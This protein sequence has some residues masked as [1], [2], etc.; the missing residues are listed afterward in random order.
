MLNNRKEKGIG[1]VG[2][3]YR[4]GFHSDFFSAQKP[5][6]SWI[7]VITENYLPRRGEITRPIQNLRLLRKDYPVALH[8][9]SLSLGSPEPISRDYLERVKWLEQ[10]ID[11]WLVSDHLCWTGTA[12]ENLHDLLPLPFTEEALRL[13]AGK[14]HLVQ[15]FLQRPIAIEN[16]SY[17][18]KPSQSEMGEAEFMNQLHR[19]T[20]CRFLLDLNNIYVNAYNLGLGPRDFL[21]RLNL[22]QVAE[23]HLAGHS[24]DAN[25]VKVDTHGAPVHE[26][27]WALYEWVQ[28][29]IGRVPT[30]IERDSN[31]PGWA[32]LNAELDILRAIQG[33]GDRREAIRLASPVL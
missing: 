13:V 5:D 6:V 3:G 27:V 21:S 26:D 17:Y 1:G 18:L 9:V 30:M 33:K 7:E 19:R 25:G 22:E 20:G 23:I 31:I 16:I 29:K 11:P 4:P 8:G 28:Q 32:E 12:G 2:V 14:I 10:D 15:D 24:V